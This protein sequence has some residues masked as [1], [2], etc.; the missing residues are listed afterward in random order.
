MTRDHGA[1]PIRGKGMG[2]ILSA[3]PIPSFSLQT[4]LL[5]FEITSKLTRNI[6]ST[7]IPFARDLAIRRRGEKAT[8]LKSLTQ[9]DNM[10][11]GANMLSLNPR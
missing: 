11:T 5:E 4:V 6:V 1:Y 8:P 9:P 10:L 7:K 3:G 2:S